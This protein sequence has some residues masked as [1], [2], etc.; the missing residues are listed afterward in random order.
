MK[1]YYVSMMISTA[2]LLTAC[3]SVPDQKLSPADPVPF[4]IGTS[5]IPEQ[6]DTLTTRLLSQLETQ[7][8]D[9]AMAQARI[10]AAEA[11]VRANRANRWPSL[12]ASTNAQRG[13]KNQPVRGD[14]ATAGIDAIW[15][16]DLS[17]RLAA[18]ADAAR[19]R[20]DV[21]V[22]NLDDIRRMM[23][24]SLRRAII[25]WHGARLIQTETGRL[26]TA[27][28]DQLELFQIR[29]KAGLID[30]TFVQRARAQRDQTATQIPLAEIDA[31]TAQYQI[32]HL[33]GLAP[34]SL[35]PLLAGYADAPLPVPA[36]KT[37]LDI[38]V[39]I[40][41][42]RPDVAAA[43]A[44]LV[45]AQAD[46][47]VAEAAWW[48][49]LSLGGFFGIQDGSALLASNPAWLL[50]GLLTMPIL[51][52]GRIDAAI[53]RANAQSQLASITY[54]KTLLNATTE[55]HT[56][57]AAFVHGHAALDQ[58][59]VARDERQN[60]VSLARSRFASGLTDMTDLT[61]AQAE[62]D[63]A[64]IALV[65]LYITTALAYVNLLGAMG[66]ITPP[67]TTPQ[68]HQPSG[69]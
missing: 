13:N 39:R 36:L 10:A 46:L 38:P 65:R 4:D 52:F 41:A 30:D 48:P 18:G 45:A 11:D 35:T 63:Q 69:H 28:E 21:A 6:D 60:T 16:P 5:G 49:D 51:N 50:S 2:L 1:H 42:L 25:Q 55:A 15:N 56:A 44:N 54:Q 59:R 37:V 17:G 68:P 19:A 33:L 20:R 40:L 43:R 32:E 12:S 47:A 8:L 53:D 66:D 22:S 61:T 3:A 57:L 24:L 9:I 62:L 14:A 27:Q 29:A 26:L 23:R 67:A 31:R 64:S 7:N 58:Q 34:E